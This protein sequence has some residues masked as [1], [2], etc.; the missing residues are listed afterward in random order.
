M[1]VHNW[2]WGR[3]SSPWVMEVS[4][5]EYGGFSIPGFRWKVSL[6][7][8][9]VGWPGT[10][11]IPSHSKKQDATFILISA[12]LLCGCFFCVGHEHGYLESSVAG[13]QGGEWEPLA[14]KEKP[15]Q[16]EKTPPSRQL[17]RVRTSK[18]SHLY[19][20]PIKVSTIGNTEPLILPQLWP[21]STLGTAFPL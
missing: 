11:E 10:C 15:W 16:R 7:N 1:C 14:Y 5:G 20:W 6:N 13:K 18:T 17:N 12:S 4:A 9:L 3:V 8:E 21:T 19:K 2:K